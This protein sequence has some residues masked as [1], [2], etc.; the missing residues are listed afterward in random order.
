[1]WAKQAWWCLIDAGLWGRGVTTA[2]ERVDVSIMALNHELMQ[3][4]SRYDAANPGYPITRLNKLTASRLGAG[5]GDRRFKTKA[6][7]CWGSALF[8]LEFLDGAMPRLPP[9]A[10]RILQGGKWLVKFMHELRSMGPRI[11][12]TQAHSLLDIW[13]NWMAIAEELEAWTPKAHLMY[14]LIIKSVRQGNPL[15][16]QVFADESLNRILRDALRLCHQTRFEQLG[17]VKMQEI[18]RRPHIRRRLA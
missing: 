12:T 10:A 3:W 7:E 5:R 6:M 13:K 14:H 2:E 9:L 17:M 4:Y 15:R 8:L 1:M 11:E 16:Y 18:L